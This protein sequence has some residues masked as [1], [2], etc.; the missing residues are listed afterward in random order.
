MQL[1]RTINDNK[2]NYYRMDN[3]MQFARVKVLKKDKLNSVTARTDF[4]R[5]VKRRDEKRTDSFGDEIEKA[6]TRISDTMVAE[7]IFNSRVAHEV[8]LGMHFDTLHL[9]I[10][11]PGSAYSHS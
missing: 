7:E 1:V 6:I 2:I 9:Y 4:N 3:R 11:T 8:G 10:A 5:S